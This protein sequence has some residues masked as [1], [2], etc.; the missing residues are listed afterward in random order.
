MMMLLATIWLPALADVKYSIFNAIIPFENIVDCQRDTGRTVGQTQRVWKITYPKVAT[1]DSNGVPISSKYPDVVDNPDDYYYKFVKNG[2]TIALFLYKRGNPTG[3]QVAGQGTILNFGNGCFLYEAYGHYGYF[4]SFRN[5][6]YH[7]CGS[8]LCNHIRD[9]GGATICPNCGCG[10]SYVIQSVN[11]TNT[12]LENLTMTDGLIEIE[13]THTADCTCGNSRI[14][15]KNDD[16]TKLQSGLVPHGTMPS[17]RG[18]APSK[19]GNAQYTYTFAGWSPTIVP[20]AGEATYTATYTGTVNKYTVTFKDWNGTELTKQT[21]E[22]GSA[23]TAP[24]NPTRT[25]YT[26]T[27]WDKAFDNVT[28]ALTVTA[29]YDINKFTVTFLDWDGTELDTQTVDY[30]SDATAPSDPVRIGHTFTG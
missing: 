30:G 21:V 28:S 24:S 17:Y 22:Y 19:A 1:S 16:G 2:N 13:H 10:D 7:M 3:H 9:L 15:F 11:P 6:D 5:K 4:V 26:F 27:G 14:T 23:A 12:T 8:S 18:V 20:V 25:G 29:Q